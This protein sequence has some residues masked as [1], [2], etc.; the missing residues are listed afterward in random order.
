MNT[1]RGEVPAKFP[2]QAC[3]TSDIIWLHNN[4]EVPVTMAGSGMGTPIIVPSDIG[5]AASLTRAYYNDPWIVFPGD[6]V[7]I[8][9]GPG[10]VKLI[11]DNTKAGGFY[12]LAATLLTFIPGG[13]RKAL[14]DALAGLIRDL[15]DATLKYAN[16]I[17]RANWIQMI[18]CSA[19]NNWDVKF[20]IGKA[21]VLALSKGAWSLLFDTG[22]LLKLVGDQVPGVAAV[23]YGAP[24]SLSAKQVAPEGGSGKSTDQGGTGSGN[25][26]NPGSSEG[27]PG[28]EKPPGSSQ[29]G[30]IK[31]D[32]SG[33]HPK[34]IRMTLGGF[35]AGSW[36]Y[37]CHFGSGGDQSFTLFSSGGTQTIDNGRTCYTGIP[38]DTVWVTI[39]S[40]RSNTISVAPPPQPPPPPPPPPPSRVVSLAQGPAAPAGYRYAVAISGFSANSNVTVTCHDSADPQG[41][42]TFVMTTNGS[43]AASTS[44]Q[45]YSGDG[46]D[47]WVRAAGIESNHVTW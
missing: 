21:G 24:I 6:T 30:S 3:L 20:A 17:T 9:I 46:P 33:A 7:R 40:A 26:T 1:S 34:W 43:G 47:H 23:V 42:Y 35:S 5:I 4:L 15:I 13:V 38:G 8:P 10:S 27:T 28:S 19:Q 2:L 44:N 39:A 41:F 29:T 14:Y 11:A 16:C 45:C 12:V 37:T 32:W 25:T 22:Y 36:R 18:A 31:I